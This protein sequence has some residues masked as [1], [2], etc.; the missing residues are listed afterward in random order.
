MQAEA[1]QEAS[2]KARR[3]RWGQKPVEI[4]VK[5]CQREE[6]RQ[7]GPD[8]RRLGGPGSST[9]PGPRESLTP[10]PRDPA[11]ASTCRRAE[12]QVFQKADSG[13]DGGGNKIGRSP[14][15]FLGIPLK[16]QCGP[17]Q[18]WLPGIQG[19]HPSLPEA[20]SRQEKASR[21][22]KSKGGHAAQ[23]SSRAGFLFL[24]APCPVSHWQ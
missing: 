15:G 3:G 22:R 24:P 21:Q 1:K 9:K 8:Q 2:P 4:L 14:R 23:P 5:G 16:L 7:S 13:V 20:W 12:A 18:I 19:W 11:L 6:E 17:G 10:R